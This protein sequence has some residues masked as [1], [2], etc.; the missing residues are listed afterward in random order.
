[1]L[2]TIIIVHARMGTWPLGKSCYYT[3]NWIIIS[4]LRVRSSKLVFRVNVQWTNTERLYA[5]NWRYF[6]EKCCTFCVTWWERTGERWSLHMVQKRGLF[7]LPTILSRAILEI[8]K[9]GTTRNVFSS[10]EFPPRRARFTSVC[11][12]RICVHWQHSTVNF[13]RFTG[14]RLRSE[15]GPFAYN[16]HEWDCLALA[17][18]RTL[19]TYRSSERD[20]IRRGVHPTGDGIGFECIRR[21]TLVH[22]SPWISRPPNFLIFAFKI[23][24][25]PMKIWFEWPCLLA[26]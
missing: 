3:I 25:L 11:T 15:L 23:V 7:D 26:L 4:R 18:K 5:K 21:R 19:R 9:Y 20:K 12:I 2:A 10:V 6:S 14:Q 16:A 17:H 24:L 8:G 1:M 22:R 13:S